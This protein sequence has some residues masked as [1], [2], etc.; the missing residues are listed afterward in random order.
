M[1]ASSVKC[2]SAIGF[3]SLMV[4]LSFQASG[5]TRTD[6][7]MIIGDVSA[8]T[9]IKIAGLLSL[10]AYEIGDVVIANHLGEQ[11]SEAKG[12]KG[13]LLKDVLTSVDFGVENPRVLSEYYFV[14]KSKDDYTVVY[15]WNELFNTTVGE[16]VFIVTS[17]NG[18][19]I[20]DM[21]DAILMVAPKDFRTGRRYLKYL[22][23]VEVKR[24]R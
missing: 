19:G 11:K 9:T 22:E 15:S 12:L 14:C 8:P 5:Q 3:A 17:K 6:A 16:S 10:K 21:H 23:F 18:I 7:F 1:N 20:Q 2:L 24:A 4:I 13:V